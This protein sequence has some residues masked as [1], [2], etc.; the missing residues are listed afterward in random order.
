MQAVAPGSTLGLEVF[1]RDSGNP[2]VTVAPDRQF[3]SASVVK[4]LIAVDRV[5]AAGGAALPADQQQQVHDMLA[6]S[7]DDIADALWEQDG[8]PAIVTR[9]AGELG[10]PGTVPP[11]D[12]TQWG[13][14]LI[15]AQDVVTIYRYITDRLPEP[16]R[17]LVL[18]AL[19]DVK[20]QAADGFDQ[21]FGIP[22]GIPGVPRAVK[23]GWMSAVSEDIL[24]TTG[25]VGPDAR[26]VIVLLT[27]QST[28]GSWST[29]TQALTGGIAVLAPLIRESATGHGH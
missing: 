25:L 2:V 3:Y 22:D 6:N 28:D 14:T 20:P 1:D 21:D 23:Q 11:D 26:Y 7:D 16:G 8:G 18:S 29:A 9:M 5:V 15:T 24:H 4:L 17:G 13:N 27:S 12:P 19:S 10:L